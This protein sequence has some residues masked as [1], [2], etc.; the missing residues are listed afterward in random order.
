MRAWFITCILC[1]VLT[2]TFADIFCEKESISTVDSTQSIMAAVAARKPR[3]VYKSSMTDRSRKW[4]GHIHLIE[5]EYV[6]FLS[7]S[8]RADFPY[9]S[10]KKLDPFI[11]LV[12]HTHSFSPSEITGFPAHPHR[13]GVGA[14]LC[15]TW[16]TFVSF[17]PIEDLRL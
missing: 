7:S 8:T 14:S 16:L 6:Q 9:L 10:Y 13:H 5:S 4:G 2:S 11:F 1:I 17:F 3:S 12:H 15:R